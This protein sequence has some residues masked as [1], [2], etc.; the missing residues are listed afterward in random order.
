M[1]M[2]FLRRHTALKLAIFMVL[3]GAAMALFSSALIYPSLSNAEQKPSWKMLLIWQTMWW[4][5]WV[6]LVPVILWL[7]QRFRLTAKRW[8][9]SLPVHVVA[10]AVLSLIH[11]LI[12][13]IFCRIL[14]GD[15]WKDIIE[16]SND[17][18]F[19]VLIRLVNALQVNFKLRLLVYIGVLM[20]SHAL[21]YYRRYHEAE[22]ESIKLETQLSMA[23]M[24]ALKM[25]LQP[26]FLFNTLHSVSALLY[27]NLPIADEMISRLIRFL[28]MTL[29]NSGEQIVSLEK[30]LEF[31]RNYLEIEQ[32]RFQDRLT[33]EMNI[34]PQALT[35]RVPNLIMQ[36]IVENAIL[37]GI[38]PQSGAGA[39]RIS[40][41][42][43]NG[44]LELQ[45][46][47]NG[48]GLNAFGPNHFREGLGLANTRS[49][50]EQLYGSAQRMM[51][52]N[53]EGGGLV[54]TMEF[55]FEGRS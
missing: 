33:V 21:Y 54:V 30:E 48:P 15:W 8:W 5:G 32:V 49:R 45:I 17:T 26:H 46:Q 35:A 23:Q 34:E 44:K 47:D 36:P 2:K 18:I 19:T 10:A 52:A 22:L 28:T 1:M 37:H 11:I 55:P 20:I 31:L 41:Q 4:Y 24:Q 38:A 25:Q 16:N 50:L 14:G 12:Y 51:L 43:K 9:T 39:I 7:S 6:P 53:A 3:V 27:T 40:A 42:R 13:V 29:E